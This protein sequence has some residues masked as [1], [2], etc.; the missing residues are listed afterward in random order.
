MYIDTALLF[1]STLYLTQML[2]LQRSVQYFTLVQPFKNAH[3][4]P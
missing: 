3:E 1:I 4:S 2:G